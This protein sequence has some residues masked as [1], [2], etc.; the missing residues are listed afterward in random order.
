MVPKNEALTALS[1]A[2]RLEHE[3]RAFYLQVAEKTR[4]ATCRATFLSLAD[5][6]RMHGEMIERQLHALEGEGQYVL[7]PDISAPDIDLGAKLFAPSRAQAVAKAGSHVLDIDA[8]HLALEM[9]IKSYDLY[10]Q[11]AQRTPDAAGAQMYRWL[12][13]AEM[14]HFNLLMGNYEGL[15]TR[16]SWV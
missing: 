15:V 5:D 14:T 2:L 8:L 6:E 4:D 13:S 16:S 9:E 11:A 10:R 12:A 7:L 1:Q 3:G